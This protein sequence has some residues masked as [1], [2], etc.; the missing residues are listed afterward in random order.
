MS[1]FWKAVWGVERRPTPALYLT[2]AVL[3]LDCQ[4]LFEAGARHC[5]ACAGGAFY[6]LATWMSEKRA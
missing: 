1:H 3:C 4:R 2:N 6:P 5:P